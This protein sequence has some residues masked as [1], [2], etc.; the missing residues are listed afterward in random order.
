MTL[1]QASAPSDAPTTPGRTGAPTWPRLLGELLAGRDLAAADTAW[2]MERVMRGEAGDVPLAGFLV[3]LRAKGETSAELAGLADAMLAHAVPLHVAGPTVDLVGTGG[4]QAHTVNISTMAA[5]VLAGAGHRVVKHGNRASSSSS[6]SADV[7]EALGVDLDLPPARVGEVAVEAGITFCFAKVFHPAFRYA[8]G[9]RTGLGVPTAFN[10]LGPLTNPAR[11]DATAV[12]VA[13]ARMA[14]LVAGVLAT[15]GTAALVFRS[16]NGLDELTT[17]SPA[18][19]WAVEDGRVREGA[20][21]AVAELGMAPATLADLRGADARHNAGVARELLAGAR[22]P[23]R[24][25]VVLNAAAAMVA[26]GV[27]APAPAAHDLVEGLAPHLAEG[28]RRAE[29]ALDSGAAERVLQRWVAATR[30]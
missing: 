12:G 11:T 15:R 6:G 4:D 22:G 3:A 26:A 27:R 19:V 13:D 1:P 10:V 18:R 20:V 8:A 2:A 5:L 28:V 21:D 16:D 29:E 23:V 30:A 14:P 17:T 9:A 25:A 7:L 24:D